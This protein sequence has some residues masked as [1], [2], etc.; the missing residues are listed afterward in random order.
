MPASKLRDTEISTAG[1]PELWRSTWRRFMVSD[2]GEECGRGA[3]PLPTGGGAWRLGRSGKNAKYMQK[4]SNLVHICLYFC[5]FNMS[6]VLWHCWLGGRKGIQPVKMGEW[7]KVG[8]G[9]SVCSGAQPAGWC[10]P[11]LI[12][13]CS[14]KPR[15][16]LLAPAHPVGP[17]KRAT[18]WL[19]WWCG[20]SA[21]WNNCGFKTFGRSC[22]SSGSQKIDTCFQETWDPWHSIV[23]SKRWV[24]WPGFSP[25]CTSTCFSNLAVT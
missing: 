12:F 24:H 20:V 9:Q 23:N 6:L 18:K 17:G 22:S 21:T 25:N 13:P 11:L 3:V 19:W 10:L 4:R 16:S 2:K 14:I 15:S 1:G 5:Y 7:W 8:T